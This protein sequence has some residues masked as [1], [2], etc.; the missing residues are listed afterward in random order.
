MPK[1][2]WW[3]NGS[4]GVDSEGDGIDRDGMV[5]MARMV[6]IVVM[7]MVLMVVM[8]IMMVRRMMVVQDMLML[9]G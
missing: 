2:W 6:L 1:C 3:L 9:L 5:V 4:D 7:V 8:V